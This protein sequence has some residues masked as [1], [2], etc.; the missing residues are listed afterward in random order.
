MAESGMHSAFK[1]KKAAK[2]IDMAS[3]HN[4]ANTSIFFSNPTLYICGMKKMAGAT[5]FEPITSGLT[6]RRSA[7]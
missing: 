3:I 6:V 4:S 7:N 5:G 2:N 1:Q